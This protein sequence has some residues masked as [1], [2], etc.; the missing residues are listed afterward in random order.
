MPASDAAAP[1]HR[2]LIDNEAWA[3]YLDA[4]KR[5]PD[6]DRRLIVARAELG[7]NSAQLAFAERLSSP[8]VARVALRRAV[9]RLSAL[10]SDG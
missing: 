10:M 3:R 5:L 9:L 2:E 8:A 4:L 1:Q 7:Y 6:R